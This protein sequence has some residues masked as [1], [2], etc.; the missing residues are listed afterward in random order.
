V[1][2]DVTEK[3]ELEA[4]QRRNAEQIERSARLA[5]LGELIGGV[6]HELNNPLTAI[7]G[8]AEVMAIEPGRHGEEIDVIRKEALRARDVVRD[9]LFIAQ[10]GSIEKGEVSVADVIAHIERL[11]RTSW[12][13]LGASVTVD[14]SRAETPAWGNEHQLTQVLLNLITNAEHAVAATVAPAIAITAVSGPEGAEI[15]V[16]D[17]GHG[18]DGGT[19]ERIFEPFFTTRRGAGTG[20]GLSLSHTIV[21]AHGGRLEVESTPGNGSVFRVVLPARPGD[22]GQRPS[23]Q[24]DDGRRLRVLVVDDEPS[25]RRVCQRLV[26]SLGHAC[27]TAGTAA[28]AAELAAA[29]NYDL[30]ICD[31]R[32]AGE[33]A[34]DVVAALEAVAPQLLPRTVV[35]TGATADPSVI[36]LVALH[37][38]HLIAKPYGKSEIEALLRNAASVLDD[39][40]A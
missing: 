36:E 30:V 12:Q 2:A 27:D 6:A 1:A 17:N 4:E 8:F 21:N 24:G 16:A 38:L 29:I 18:M 26:T 37:G 34:D 14:V 19:R 3:V 33:T 23:V 32:L 7:L 15:T 20:L 22:L 5:A 28:D 31:Y 25:L 10:P 9:L 40:A 13:Q 39:G 11:R 35:A